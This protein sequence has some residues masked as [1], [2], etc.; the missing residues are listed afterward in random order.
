MLSRA[1]EGAVILLSEGWLNPKCFSNIP[2]QSRKPVQPCCLTRLDT[3]IQ[4]VACT[5][6]TVPYSEE[7]VLNHHL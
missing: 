4:T 5:A 1:V 6:V 2:E 3:R 7:L